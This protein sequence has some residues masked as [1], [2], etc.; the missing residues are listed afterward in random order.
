MATIKITD[1][2]NSLTI[3]GLSEA[4]IKKF[5]DVKTFY[6]EI[7]AVTKDDI[8]DIYEDINIKGSFTM[9]IMVPEKK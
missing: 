5:K 6:M 3:P 9:D 7:T 1:N 4:E 8:E 2:S